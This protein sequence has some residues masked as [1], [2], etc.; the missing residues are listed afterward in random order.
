MFSSLESF[1]IFFFVC[2]GL[3]VSAIV[4][5]DKLIALEEKRIAKRREKRNEKKHL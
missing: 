3:I 4:F 2:L 1:S 5:E